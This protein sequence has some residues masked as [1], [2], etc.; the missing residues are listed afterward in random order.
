M[1]WRTRSLLLRIAAMVVA[2]LHAGLLWRRVEDLSITEPQVLARWSAAAIAV[3][4]G[5]V[6]LHLRV[7][8]RSWL[9]FWTVIVL[10]HAFAPS[11]VNIDVLTE[12]VF[13]LGPLILIVAGLTSRHRPGSSPLIVEGNFALPI[14]L[15]TASLPSRAPPARSFRAPKPSREIAAHDRSEVSCAQQQL[16]F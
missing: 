14:T 7:S 6:L 10:L 8:R 13:V 11:G 16:W 5:L 1:R 4:I 2:A 12:A 3:A 9:V 15:L